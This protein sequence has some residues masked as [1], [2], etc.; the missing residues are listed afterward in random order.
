MTRREKPVRSPSPRTRQAGVLAVYKTSQ[1]G[2]ARVLK[3]KYVPFHTPAQCIRDAARLLVPGWRALGIYVARSSE[4]SYLTIWFGADSAGDIH[5]VS[6]TLTTEQASLVA[7]YALALEG[8]RT[9]I[10]AELPA[11]DGAGGEELD[12]P[13]ISE[14]ELSAMVPTTAAGGARVPAELS[15][16]AGGN[17]SNDVRLRALTLGAATTLVFQC[18]ACGNRWSASEPGAKVH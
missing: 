5:F 9:L 16:R 1:L 12:L 8:A 2:K 13:T 3:R 4:K 17:G 6:I 18:P 7:V 14:A 10:N 15:E 11:A